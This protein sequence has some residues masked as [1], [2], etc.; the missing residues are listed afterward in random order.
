[1]P[2][3]PK[4]AR[5][6]PYSSN[7]AAVIDGDHC[8]MCDRPVFDLTAMSDGERLA[9]L[10]G[11]GGEVCV[12]YAVA[13]RP[14]L[15]AAAMAAAIAMPAAAA[16]APAVRPPVPPPL[17]VVAGGLA[18]P[19]QVQ[20]V[21]VPKEAASADVRALYDGAAGPPAASRGSRQASPPGR[22]AP[23]QPPR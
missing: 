12:S 3:F 20:V 6:C 23:G 2:L 11:C 5:P 14:A 22:P 4:I 1:M 16:G 15:R 7:L 8:R 19:P 17:V 21:E 9:F 10:A 18:P 13:L